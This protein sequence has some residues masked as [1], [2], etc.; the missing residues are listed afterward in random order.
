MSKDYTQANIEVLEGLEPVRVRP[1]MYIGSTDFR[2]LHHLAK[3]IIDNSVDE[4][5]AGF[6]NQIIITINKDNSVIVSDNGRGIPVGIKEGYGVSALELVLTKLHAGGKFNGGGY[7][8]S[9]GLHGVGSSVVN[10][11]SDTFRVEVITDGNL[12][13]QEYARGKKTYEVKKDKIAKSKFDD[14]SVSSREKGTTIYFKPDA[15]IFDTLVYDYKTIK[16]QV[17]TFAY[18]TSGL[19]F[20]LIDKRTDTIESFY[21]E[22]GLKS[23][24]ASLNRNKKTIHDNIF[25]TNKTKN[26]MEVEIA[27]QYTDSFNSNELSFA[28]NIKTP[29][30]GTHLTGFRTA[31]TKVI[32]DYGKANNL[33]KESDKPTGQD[34]LEGLTAA[35]SIKI[36]S[37]VL[38]FEGQ[39]KSKLGTAEAKNVVE[40]VAKEAL[41]EFFEEN[42][43]DASLIIDKVILA[44]RARNAARAARDSIIRKSAL[45]GSGLPGKLADCRTK[46]PTRAEI[47]IVEG[48]SAGGTAKKARD[49]E[50]QAILPLFGKPLNTERA[51]LDQVVKNEKFKYL[52]Q[53]LG[54]GIGE[55]FE[56]KNARYHKIIIMADADVDGSHIRTLYL[57]FMFRHL[58]PVIDAGLLYAAVPPLYKATF[59]KQRKYLLDDAEKDK[60]EKEMRKTG[61]K[62]VIS[63]FKGLGEMDFE[64]L[65]DTTMDPEKRLLKQITI[66]DAEEADKV[67]DMLMG[68][69]AAPRKMFI[70]ANA[71]QAELDL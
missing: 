55:F 27:F 11:L 66:D 56:V 69:E 14:E 35:V 47:F 60:F 10:A 17:K 58:R 54:T 36:P 51:R 21:F 4:A 65:R 68:Q 63:R 30:G 53:A 38:Q 45:E 70:Q 6:C 71:A 9:G 1:G 2:G 28:N 59:G 8:I 5:M 24:T 18:L 19:R 23:L 32:N 42:P 26:D 40:A 41:D 50:F 44:V 62:Y 52:I 37:N 33:Y 43:R 3:E 57:T 34:T 12:Y 13:H 16:S 15:T 25:Y 49:S 7:K 22:G 46:D 48:D 31:L 61:K 39:T 67:F 64:D 20:K 29:D